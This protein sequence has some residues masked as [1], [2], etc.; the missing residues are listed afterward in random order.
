M[1]IISRAGPVEIL[2][3]LYLNTFC[4]LSREP[5][6]LGLKDFRVPEGMILPSVNFRLAFILLR[7][8][9]SGNSF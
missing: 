3:F 9:L 5:P 1:D 7:L 6:V 8:L 4:I 2:K